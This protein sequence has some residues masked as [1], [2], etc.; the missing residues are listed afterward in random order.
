MFHMHIDSLSGILPSSQDSHQYVMSQR[1]QKYEDL[2]SAIKVMRLVAA[3]AGTS[4]MFLKMFLL[5]SGLLTFEE[6]NMVWKDSKT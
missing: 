2:L 3:D 1:R 4:E 5:E 6:H